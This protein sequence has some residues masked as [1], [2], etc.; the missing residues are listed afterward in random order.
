ML[1]GDNIGRDAGL[2]AAIGKTHQLAHLIDLKSKIART[3]DEGQAAQ[4]RTFI[5]P[6]IPR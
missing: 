3:T 4:M 6:V 2:I 5:G 1:V